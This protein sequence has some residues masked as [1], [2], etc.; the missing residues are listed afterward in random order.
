MGAT[1][2]AEYNKVVANASWLISGK[3]AQMLL[4]LVVG[5]ISARYLGPSN[6]GLIGYGNALVS[7][8][9][10]FCTLGINSIII[11]DFFD[12][13]EEKGKA[14]GS[15][16]L[17]RILSSFCS[18][19]MVVAISFFIDYG[20]WETVLVVALCS[21]SLLFHCFDTI[22]YYFQS[23]YLSK[24][25][26][27]AT[28]VAYVVTASY[29]IVLLI[30]KKSVFWFAFASSVDYIVLAVFL[31]IVYKKQKGPKLAASWSKGKA[32]LRV[33]YHYILSGLMVAIYGHTDAFML[34]L[35]L[36]E[37]AVGYYTIATTLCGMWTFVLAAII[38]SMYPTIIKHF[39]SGS[40]AS[41]EKKNRQLYALV[42]YISAF[43]SVMFL[44]LGDFAIWLLYGKEFLPAA[45]P[46]KVVTWYTAFSYFGVARNAWVVCNEKQNYLKYMY[47]SAAVINIGLNLVLIPLWGAVGAAVASLITQICTSIVLPFFVKGFRPN[48]KLMLEAIFLKD[49]FP[50]KQDIKTLGE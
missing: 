4:S 8:F 2:K 42:F 46:L 7:F 48:V 16:I 33:S 41:F 22:N 6:Y 29:K 40:T 30:L 37:T 32:L 45:A 28:F 39:K 26:A 11:K 50:S 34:K 9:M 19:V 49:V 47:V 44:L 1:G 5:T 27:I 38:D 24:I 17:M 10:S 21:V 15:A 3:I 36:D 43:V 31:L 35:M 20:E 25:T 23:L 14:L 18:V 13:P 12:H